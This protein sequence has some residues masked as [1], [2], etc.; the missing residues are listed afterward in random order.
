MLGL[1]LKPTAD[2]NK[3]I[4]ML[5]RTSTGLRIDDWDQITIES[6]NISLEKFKNNIEAYSNKIAKQGKNKTEF[7]KI[8]YIDAFGHE[9][10]KTFEKKE[11]SSQAKLLYNDAEAMMEEYGESL[12]SEEKRQVLVDIINKVLI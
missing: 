2:T 10:F 11:Y 4:E 9:E 5:A 8:S 7:Y 1:C 6:Y 3:F 12:S